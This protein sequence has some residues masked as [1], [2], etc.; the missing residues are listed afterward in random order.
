MELLK[1]YFQHL[2]LDYEVDDLIRDFP[3]KD[4]VNGVKQANADVLKELDI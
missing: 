1:G 4:N 3:A 2:Y